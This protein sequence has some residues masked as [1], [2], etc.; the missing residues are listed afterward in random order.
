[1]CASLSLV[2]TISHCREVWP[3][4]HILQMGRIWSLNSLPRAGWTWRARWCQGF[5]REAS[6]SE[7]CPRWESPLPSQQWTTGSGKMNSSPATSRLGQ[8]TCRHLED[9]CPGG[10]VSCPRLCRISAGDGPRISER[11]R[12]MSL[13]RTKLSVSFRLFPQEAGGRQ[14]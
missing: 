7:D 2:G 13:L 11:K 12:R 8:S 3:W 10:Q 14:G 4:D 6:D 5:W 1:M 9:R